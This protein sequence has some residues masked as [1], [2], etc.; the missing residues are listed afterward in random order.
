MYRSC[1]ARKP[2]QTEDGGSFSGRG[3][4][5]QSVSLQLKAD[6]DEMV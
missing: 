5:V 2:I 1:G 3:L 4:A 6:A